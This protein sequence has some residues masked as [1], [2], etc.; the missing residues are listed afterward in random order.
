MRLRCLNCG[1]KID[2]LGKECPHC[3]AEKR[4][5]IERQRYLVGGTVGG[6]IAGGLLGYL[7]GG[8]V[9]AVFTGFAGLPV[10]ILAGLA[11]A[12]YLRQNRQA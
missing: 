12:W 10:G 5:S 6:V 1:A 11:Y 4:P 7:F 3:H 2:S 9:G 8:G